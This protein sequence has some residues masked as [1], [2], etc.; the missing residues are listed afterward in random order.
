[1]G[2]KAI[3]TTVTEGVWGESSDEG[4]WVNQPAVSATG[5]HSHPNT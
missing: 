4:A 2:H 3:P 1:M 5:G